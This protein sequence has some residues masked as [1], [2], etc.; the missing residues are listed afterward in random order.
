MFENESNKLLENLFSL[1][2]G[3]GNFECGPTEQ[4][5]GKHDKQIEKLLEQV[6]E[7]DRELF[8]C[9]SCRAESK[10]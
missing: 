9:R 7:V 4:A 5:K 8:R 2:E 6:K 10:L 1:A 3:N